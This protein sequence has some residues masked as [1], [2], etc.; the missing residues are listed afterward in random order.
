MNTNSLDIVGRVVQTLL[1][2]VIRL[3]PGVV[4]Y[5]VFAYT[6]RYGYQDFA[7]GFTAVRRA[8]ISCRTGRWPFWINTHRLG[9]FTAD[10]GGLG[11]T[12]CCSLNDSAGRGF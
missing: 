6:L 11:R 10:I 1:D 12:C 5:G 8:T 2:R 7:A 4:M 9:C 3:S